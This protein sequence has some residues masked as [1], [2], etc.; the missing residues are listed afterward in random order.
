MIVLGVL[1]VVVAVVVSVG[2]GLR[3]TQAASIDLWWFTVN[4]TVS[5]FYFTGLVLMTV[6]VLGLW[7]LLRGVR[8]GYRRR[9]EMRELR[10]RAQ[11]VEPVRE[12]PPAPA[13]AAP[14]EPTRDADDYFDSAPREDAAPGAT[15]SET[16]TDT[17]SGDGQTSPGTS[18]GSDAREP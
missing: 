17:A 16:P 9:K 14:R 6:A 12:T 18:E 15:S 4:T 10:A 5:V 3:A 1:L 7:L 2:I 8:R 11:R 13:P